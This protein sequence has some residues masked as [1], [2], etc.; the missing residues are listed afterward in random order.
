[1]ST[2]SFHTLGIISILIKQILMPVLFMSWLYYRKNK[3]KTNLIIKLLFTWIYFIFIFFVESWGFTSSYLRYVYLLIFFLLSVRLITKF[4][5]LPTWENM[6]F[7]GWAK[8]CIQIFFSLLFLLANIDI[9]SG[10]YT[11]E[12]GINVSF[13]LNEGHIAHGGNS[14]II[15]YH[16]RDT[17]AQHYAL[18]I[19]RLDHLGRRASGFFPDDLTKYEIYGDTIFAPCD[20]KIVKVTDGLDNVPAGVDVKTNPAGNHLVLEYQNSLIVFAHILKN[21]ILVSTGEFV[22]KG[23]PMAQVGNSG[24]TSEPHLHIHAIAGTD[25]G[26]IIKGGAHGIPIYFDGKFVKRNDVVKR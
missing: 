7:W 12:A 25:T 4:K 13:P 20:G 10:L 23:Q 11:H 3:S 1:M 15:N 26:K 22:K 24:H 8:M 21:S 9:I 5:P 16:Q 18:D 14:E 2:G 17:T 6:K 19:D